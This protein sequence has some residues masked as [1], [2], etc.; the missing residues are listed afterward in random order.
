MTLS[1]ARKFTPNPILEAN[2]PMKHPFILSLALGTGWLLSP[3]SLVIAGNTAGTMGW[4]SIPALAVV[5]LL[6]GLSGQLLQQPQLPANGPREFL[7][8]QGLAGTLGARALTLS[9]TLP[10]VVLGATAL[11]VTSGYTFNEV[12]LYWFPTFG[13]SFLLLGLLTLLQFFPEKII[14]WAQICFVAMAGTGLLFLALSGSGGTPRALAP[15]LTGP[16]TFPPSSSAALLLLFVGGTLSSAKRWSL[17]RA[18]LAFVLLS[19]WIFASLRYVE[20]SHLASSTIP[21]MTAARKI[22]GDPGRQIM[23]IVVISGSAAAITGL[24]LSCRQLLGDITSRVNKSPLFPPF[25]Q[26]W[27]L[28]PLLALCIGISMAS[29]LAG[30]EILE[31]LLRAALLLWLLYYTLLCLA[32]LLRLKKEARPMPL[33]GLSSTLILIISLCILVSNHPQRT[34]LLLFIIAILGTSALLGGIPSLINKKSDHQPPPHS[35]EKII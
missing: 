26:R 19:L 10:L 4:L 29:G 14:G 17:P 27:L 28:P 16:S 20:H 3:E 23:G 22:M 31:V 34:T 15:V 7:L 18:T 32:A 33:T 13:F 6:F 1:L 35:L 21:Y 25:L 9:A 30:H 8:L 12:F 2:L 24:I 5:A 11:L